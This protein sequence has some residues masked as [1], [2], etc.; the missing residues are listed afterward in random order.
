MTSND[1]WNMY[2]VTLYRGQPGLCRSL[3]AKQIVM[4]KSCCHFDKLDAD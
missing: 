3:C 1:K 2:I 4:N